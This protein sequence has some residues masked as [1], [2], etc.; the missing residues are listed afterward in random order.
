MFYATKNR[1][2]S[3]SG[4]VVRRVAHGDRGWRDNGRF[5]ESDPNQKPDPA[6]VGVPH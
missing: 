3:H 4:Y 1:A 2:C 5:A 6:R